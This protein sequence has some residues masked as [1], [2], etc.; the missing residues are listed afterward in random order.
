LVAEGADLLG[1]ESVGDGD[2]RA[3]HC[4]TGDAFALFD[5]NDCDDVADVQRFDGDGFT[6]VEDVL[7]ATWCPVEG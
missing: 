1:W 2:R 4:L 3:F 7:A 6:S 5:W